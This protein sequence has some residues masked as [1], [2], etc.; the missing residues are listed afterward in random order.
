M[1]KFPIDHTEWWQ[2]DAIGGSTVQPY[3]KIMAAHFQEYLYPRT[4]TLIFYAINSS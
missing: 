2:M 1:L 3:T 4:E